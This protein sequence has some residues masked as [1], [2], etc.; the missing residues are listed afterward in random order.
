MRKYLLF[1]ICF[2]G[3]VVFAN[4]STGADTLSANDSAHFYTAADG[5]KIY[6]EVHGEG[7]PVVLV[8]GFI[9]NAQ[10]W[11]NSAVYSSLVNAGYKVI[12]IDLRGNG[13]SDKPHDCDA[14]ANDAEA[15]DIMGIIT[16]LDIHR[17]TAVGYSRGSIITAR[18][19]VLDERAEQAVMGG[20]GTDFTNPNWPRRI[21]FY[22]ALSGERV[23]ELAQMVK[24]VKNNPKLDIA[25][26]ACMQKNQPSTSK[27]DL[28]KVRK[29]VL[30]ICGDNDSDNGNAKAL[31]DLFVLSSFVTVPGD[32]GAA[33]Q[34]LEFA[35]AVAEWLKE[36]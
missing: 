13:Q 1:V 19:L 12:L 34:T 35:K 11:K 30:V 5:V 31:A 21:M 33:V 28:A 14:F 17:Y 23:P 27:E 2:L 36:Q 29:R 3:S 7:Y 15:K 22:K 8:H 10:S 32:H 26:L 20:M 4:A 18:L 16:Q 6:Y 24:N 25:A 9:V